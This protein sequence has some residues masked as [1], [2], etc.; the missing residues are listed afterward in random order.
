MLRTDLL[1]FGAGAVFGI[2]C[3]MRRL[4]AYF[5]NPERLTVIAANIKVYGECLVLLRFTVF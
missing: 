4:P 1:I 3:E 2:A 5:D